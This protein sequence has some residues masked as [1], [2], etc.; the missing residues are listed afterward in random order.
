MSIS[1]RRNKVNIHSSSY[2][3]DSFENTLTRSEILEY[4]GNDDDNTN[5]INHLDIAQGLKDILLIHGFNL[6]SLLIMRSY[7]LAEMLGIDEY[8]AKIIISAAYDINNKRL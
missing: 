5:I 4:S 1:S 7:D 8:V 6:D 2:I 3:P